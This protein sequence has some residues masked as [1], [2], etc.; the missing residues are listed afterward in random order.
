MSEKNIQP[1]VNKHEQVSSSENLEK[2]GME[3]REAL[4]TKME[5]QELENEK[6]HEDDSSAH[7]EA[8]RLAKE[9]DDKKQEVIKESHSDVYK[10]QGAP[11]KKQ[12]K[13]SFDNQMRAVRDEL[14]IGG[15]IASKVIHNPLIE[16][17]SDFASSTFARPNA[18]LS[19]SIMAFITVTAL[20]FLAK[21]YGFQLSGFETIAAFIF[22]WLLG[23]LYDYLRS[24]FS[25]HK[26]Y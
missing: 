7:D 5:R 21:H 24:V 22:G 19:G 3:H 20:Y 6:N 26:K 11:S 16:T 13:V 2:I 4:L 14:N 18:L 25:R 8:S 10:H 12:L 9:S 17:V 15:K 23:T 1:D